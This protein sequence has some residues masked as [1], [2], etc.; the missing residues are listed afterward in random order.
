MSTSVNHIFRHESFPF[1]LDQWY[2]IMEPIT[3]KTYFIPLKLEQA[4]AIIQYYST[5]YMG[6]EGFTSQ[7]TKILEE[8]ENQ[9]D[10][11]FTTTPGLREKGAFLR[12]CGR[13][14]KDGE[15]NDP[16]RFYDEYR[17]NL[18]YLIEEKHLDPTEGNTK[19][20]AIAKTHWL[21]VRNAK[22]CLSLLLSSKKVF[23]DLSDWK[24]FGGKEQLCFR[25]F[26]EDL[27]DDNEFRG[28]VY[29]NKLTAITQYDHFG[30]F[31][32]IIQ[33][34]DKIEGMIHQFWEAEVKNRM[35]VDCY[36]VDFGYVNGK[37]ILIEV[38]PFLRTT[39][40][41]CLSWDYDAYELRY[42][43]GK[44][45]VASKTNPNADE[46]ARSFEMQWEDSND[47]KENFIKESV[48]NPTNQVKKNLLF[49]ASVLKK[50]FFWNQKYLSYADFIDDAELADHG[51]L[52]DSDGMGWIVKEKMKLKGEVWNVD[53]DDLRDIEFFYGKSCQKEIVTVKTVNGEM[54][55]NVTCFVSNEPKKEDDIIVEEFTIENGKNY[56]NVAHEERKQEK[57]LNISYRFPLE[58]ESND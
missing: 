33:A 10:N 41:G 45:K 5:F 25:E 37:I 32:D 57:Y 39:G 2:P 50:S 48:E 53:D 9:I 28:F 38:S 1:D 36:I 7:H 13:S 22:D 17:S 51:V 18:H 55:E 23:T 11:L 43:S 47:Y 29:E 54:Y 26:Y 56:N 34:K 16:Q 49:V 20:W 6:K 24:N 14:P 4:E 27:D 40:P 15:P 12:L 21:I 8:L 52:I 31:E 42:G 46:I 30:R 3:F 44:L 58:K 35:K 19:I